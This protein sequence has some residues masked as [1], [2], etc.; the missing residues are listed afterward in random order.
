M[1]CL[2]EKDSKSHK[3]SLLLQ[4][5]NIKIFTKIKKETLFSKPYFYFFKLT[6]KLAKNKNINYKIKMCFDNETEIMRALIKGT[7]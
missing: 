3:R 4:S 7:D 2:N 5:I 6:R 1:V